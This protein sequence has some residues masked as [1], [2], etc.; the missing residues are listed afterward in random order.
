MGGEE[1]REKVKEMEG[2]GS[3]RGG[4]DRERERRGEKE[5]DGEETRGRAADHESAFQ[6]WSLTLTSLDWKKYHSAQRG[7]PSP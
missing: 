7:V 1:K 6:N 4:K 3:R 2:E 5:G